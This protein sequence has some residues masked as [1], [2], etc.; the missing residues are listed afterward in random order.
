MRATNSAR[1]AR[2]LVTALVLT[3]VQIVAAPFF[4]NSALAYTQGTATNGTAYGGTGGNAN[5][6]NQNCT[7]GAVV[8]IGTTKSGSNL[9]SF[10]FVCKIINND[11]SLSAT[12]VTTNV[13]N[14]PAE[15]DRCA[16]GQI[17]IGIRAIASNGGTL[18]GGVGLIC[19]NPMSQG[20]P[21]TRSIMPDALSAGTVYTYTCATGQLL[22]GFYL[23]TGA[24]VDQLTPKCSSFSGFA[25]AAVGAPSATISGNAAAVSFAPVTGSIADTALTYTVSAVPNSGTTITVTGSASPISVPGLVLRANYTVT[26]TASNTYGT[27]PSTSSTLVSMALP[28]GETDTA[29]TFATN[30]YAWRADDNSLDIAN[31]IT[32]EAWVYQTDSYGTGWNM[33]MNKESSYELGTINGIWYY[34]LN[35]TNGGWGGVST[36]VPSELNRWQHVA[37]VRAADSNTAQFYLDGQLMWSGSSDSAGLN[38]A[39]KNSTEGFTIGGRS[40]DR[41]VV[42]SYFAGQIDEVRVYRS[43][44]TAAEINVDMNSY[45]PI[46]DP[47][48]AVYYDFNEGT[49]STKIYNRKSG[50]TDS[51][52]LTLYG[53]PTFE[54]VKSVDPSTYGAYTTLKFP[55]TYLT[56][57]GGW[58]VPSG[59]SKL[60]YLI[61]AGGGAGG[62]ATTA[63]N[64]QGGGGGGGGVRIGTITSP[65][66]FISPQVGSGQHYTTC[67][68]ERGRNSAIR[69]T[70]IDTISAT[71]GGSGGCWN[72][73]AFIN[74]NTGGSGGGGASQVGIA[75]P[76]TGNLGGYTPPEGYSGGN[77]QAD[78]GSS[79]YQ[80]GGGGGGAGAS[81]G[82]GTTTSAGNGGAG[83]VTNF[84]GSYI[85]YGGGG[86]GGT[87]WITV[88]GT[89]TDGGGAAG[90]NQA[91][92][93]AGVDGRGGGGGGTSAAKGND[94]GM[95]VVFIRWISAAKPSYTEPKIAYL[96]AGMT[97]TFTTNVASDSATVAFT[98]TFRWESSTTGVNG[99]FSTIK[100]GT[101][102]ANAAFSWVPLDT[103]TSGANFLYRVIVTDLD[104]EGLTYSD[105]STPV[106]AIINRALAVSGSTNIAKA[107]N[108][109]RNET[110]TITL[111]TSTYRP[112]LWPVIPGITLDTSTAGLAVIR[113]AETMTVGTY[114]ETLTVT[115]SVSAVV[116]IPLTIAV[117]A[118]PSLLNTNEI[119]DKDLIY[120][121]DAGN[122]QSLIMGD[123][124]VATSAV[125]RDLSGNG[126]HAQT[127]GTYDT[128]GFAKTCT[129]PTW[130]PNNGG[131]LAFNGSSTCYWSPYIGNQLDLNVSVE[132]W[133]RLDGA[134]LNSAGVIVQQNFNPG[135]TSNIS[136][137]LGDTDQ[138]G[139]VKFGLY[140]GGAYRQ[141]GGVTLAQGVW[142]HLVG[143]YDGTNFRIYK[144]GSL[145]N[146]SASY[147]A[148]LGSTVN[149]SGTLIGR[150]GSSSGSPFFN[151]SIAT[152]R[153]YD[154]ALTLAQIQQNY[155]ATKE[156][157]LS[158][159]NSM[160]RPSQKYGQSQQETFTVTSGFGTKTTSFTT[161][162]RTGIAWD[163]ATANTV[164]L[165]I[166]E[167]LTV[168]TYSDTITVTDSLNQSS[169]LPIRATIAKADT[170]TVTVRNPKTF[171]YTGAAPTSLPDIAIVGLVSSDTATATRVYSAPASGLGATDTYT[172]LVRSASVPIDVE[173]YTVTGETLTALTLGS[174]AN[175]QGVLYETST[176]IITKAKQPALLVNYFGAIAGSPFTL[177]SYGGAGTGA[178]SET[179]T[180]GSTA[181]NC[182]ITG[183][184]LSN[185]SPAGETKTCAIILTRAASRNYFIETATATIYFFAFVVNQQ[186]QTGSGPT[187]GLGGSTAII[188]DPNQAPTITGLSTTTLSLSAGGNFTIYGAGFGLSQ[189]TV[190]FWRNKSILVTSSDGSTLVVPISAISALNPT[191][192]KVL[193]INGNGTAVSVDTLAITL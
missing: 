90:K 148:G 19:G 179:T 106:Y 59:I 73:S 144:D 85:G 115:D 42:S 46:S 170:I 101:G 29:L 86:G 169:F 10:M 187:I 38:T 108:V 158:G 79:F 136:F 110:F 47:N 22:A 58:R 97:E 34:A 69:G 65:S 40:A 141:S 61:V 157:F 190:K 162:N 129:A 113:I 52:D 96:N 89:A 135:S 175:Y 123:T 64:F 36:L 184:V 11:A 83:I 153:I 176:L 100:E 4:T 151:G 67:K 109:G 94:G 24:L 76:G 168:G 63:G 95:G 49:G 119:V 112:T 82:A 132:A 118:P 3:L 17:G 137:I 5:P 172:A 160:L 92:G 145:I 6:A 107:I 116:T 37:L 39:L 185:T 44:R 62:G 78:S 9:N 173:T 150:R 14:T 171:V 138:I 181:A 131:S 50:A 7:N 161:G 91:Q 25:Y 45:G 60:S 16:A 66:G 57:T 33:V 147:T 71:G 80:S 12:E 81:G 188:N 155:N 55:R 166:Q 43:A 117:A 75:T 54:D 152:I 105:T 121:L 8:A 122:S 32:M 103:S 13:F 2:S 163:T 167:S 193:V 192:G 143:T 27:S 41:S 125:W 189:L 104:A 87:R 77:A 28:G 159:N 1:I 74:G 139:S 102:A 111:G 93:S 180:S 72:G 130:S 114:Y 31:A 48:L 127:S 15:S 70:A 21:N 146:T 30:K 177:Q 142:T 165:A 124:A 154:I 126:K 98:R 182:S 178:F 164:V 26:V 53:S 149:T 183:R 20:N 56:S 134:T 191:T 23:R 174:L 84:S 18:I 88:G 128:G 51:S 140:D 120:H 186:S 99:T 35:G 68:Q 156:R 133:V